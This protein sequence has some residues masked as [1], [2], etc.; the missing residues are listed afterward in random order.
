MEDDT[1][2][3]QALESLGLS[4][5]LAVTFVALVA[6]VIC[7]AGRRTDGAASIYRGPRTRIAWELTPVQLQSGE[8]LQISG[9]LLMPWK[10]VRIDL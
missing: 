3:V 9:A 10:I 5:A 4:H 2:V 6:A 1:P 8:R 7:E